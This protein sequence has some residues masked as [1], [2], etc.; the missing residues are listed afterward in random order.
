MG[1]YARTRCRFEGGKVVYVDNSYYI[2]TAELYGAIWA[3]NRLA[4]WRS[5][6]LVSWSRVR[7]LFTYTYAQSPPP[8]TW[9]QLRKHARERRRWQQ[10]RCTLEQAMCR[11][12]GKM[13]APP[14]TPTCGCGTTA[15]VT[16]A[17]T[18]PPTPGYSH[19]QSW[20]STPHPVV[21]RWAIKKIFQ[22]LL[23]GEKI[24]RMQ[25]YL[26]MLYWMFLRCEI[27]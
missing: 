12:S 10:Q 20:I 2:F 6:D 7:T 11:W 3:E 13:A 14:S 17:T 19:W 18:P 27:V 22:S 16:P 8:Q 15:P 9:Q 5:A 1:L 25:E 26:L 23:K 4:L 21:Y 24:K